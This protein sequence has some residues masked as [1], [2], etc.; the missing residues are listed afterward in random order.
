MCQQ[1]RHA[2]FAVAFVPRSDEDGHIDRHLRLRRIGEQ[3]NSQ[4][5]LQPEFGDS[6]DGG[7]ELRR[8]G[9]GPDGCEHSDPC[10]EEET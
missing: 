10:N 2:G 4:A 8:S 9:L 7:D 1:V 3:Q 6:L 5:V